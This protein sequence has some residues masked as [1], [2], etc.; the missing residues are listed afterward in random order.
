MRLLIVEDNKRLCDTLK[1]LMQH[2]KYT[3][4]VS[5]DGESGYDYACSD[6][7]DV[8]ILDVM[9]PKMDGF[10]LVKKLRAQ[11]INTPVLMLTAKSDISD[12]V[13]G[14]NSGADY[15][16][17]KPFESEELIACVRAVSRRQGEVVLETI[18]YGDIS[19]DI[20]N[21]TLQC[22]DK[23]VRLCRKEFDIMHMLMVNKN[24]V[25]SKET[26]LLKVWGSESGAEDNNVEVYISFLRKKLNFLKSKVNIKT[27]R[28]LGYCLE[29]KCLSS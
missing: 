7:Y 14:L 19:L 11:G 17:T 27:V 16:L 10:E 18:E 8:I 21:S 12:K 1:E 15:Y 24:M 13:E 4:D 29:D 25:I 20:T 23:D 26:L 3:V 6:V 22:Q 5:Y 2:N 28:K 9:L